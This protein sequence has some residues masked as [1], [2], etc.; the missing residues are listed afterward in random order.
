MAALR[1]GFPVNVV[2]SPGP[3]LPSCDGTPA[4]STLVRPH[5]SLLPGRDPFLATRQSVPGGYKLLDETAFCAPGLNLLGTL[6]RNALTGPGF[7]NLDLSVAKSFRAGWLG[8]S[9]EIIFR[10]DFFNALNHANLGSPDGLLDTGNNSIFG[11]A[12][13]GRQGTQPSFPSATPLDQLPR[14]VQLQLKVVF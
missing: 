9:G 5:P 4:L 10:A 13:L 1:S 8:E 6:G 3:G 14:Q 7:W 11:R 2:W 12:L